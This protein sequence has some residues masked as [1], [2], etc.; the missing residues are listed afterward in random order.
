MVAV[1]TV[2]D[3]QLDANSM[4]KVLEVPV[5]AAWEILTSREGARRWLED[6]RRGPVEIGATIPVHH[7]GAATVTGVVPGVRIELSVAS[8]STASLAF[9]AKSEGSTDLVLRHG[10]VTEPAMTGWR[11]LLERAR[12]VTGD[13]LRNRRSR[14]AIVVIHGIGNQRPLRTSRQFTDALVAR[15]ERW[16]KPDRVSRSYELRRYQ[17]ARRRRRPRTDIYELYW[18]DKVSGTV[19]SHLVRWLRGQVLR[20]PKDVSPALRPL[21][22]LFAGV[23]ALA[24]AGVVYLAV[25]LG[26]DGLSG[27]WKQITGIAGLTFIGGL[28]SGVLVKTVG[29]AARYLDDDPENIAIRQS[30]REAGVA[31]LRGLHTE[32]RYDRVVMVGHSLGSVI[33]YDLIRQYWSEVHTR[34]G[35]PTTIRQDVLRRYES[36]VESATADTQKQLWEENRRLG[37]PW[38]ISDL[39]T[40]GS[41]LTHARSLLARSAADLQAKKRD[42]E[43]PSC[44]PRPDE[45]GLTRRDD[46][47]VNG[48]RRSISLLT[49]GCPFGP[50]RWTNLYAPVRAAM[51]GDL[52]G[53]PLAP[54]FGHGI[55]DVPVRITPW[56]RRRTL[57]AHTAY[58]RRTETGTALPELLDAIDLDSRPWLDRHVAEL[59]WSMALRQSPDDLA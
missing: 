51:F 1:T 9:E 42:L 34:H 2:T 29:D 16:S 33:A 37:M 47:V 11:H 6:E 19:M 59:P 22:Y 49:Y 12:L 36:D 17:I 20:R 39:I 48:S 58:W 46:Y 24:A 28:I 23:V 45:K 38:L 21:L 15:K 8:G 25:T 30:I 7:V 55:R 27:A 44:P 14:Q 56:W 31:L 18:A 40:L 43:L 13:A 57:L 50:T 35:C 54:E 41:P 10:G 4:R 52:V 3:A 26:L 32:E 5:S 53:G